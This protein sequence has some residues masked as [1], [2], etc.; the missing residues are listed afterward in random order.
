MH[1]LDL[2]VIGNCSIATLIDKRARMVWSC[3]PRL[4]G[5]PVFCNLLM[6]NDADQQGG[7]FEIELVGGVSCTQSYIENTAVLVT[8]LSDT[9]GNSLEITDYAPRFMQF[10]RIYRPPMVVRRVRPLKGRPRI[11][12]RAT[13][14][15][16]WGA[17]E[18]EVTR[19]NSHIRFVGSTMSLRLTT[20]APVAYL[21]DTT[22][23]VVDRPLA[24][25]FGAD[26]PLR[27]GI[28]VMGR[29][30]LEKTIAH[31]QDWVRSLSI[32]F[33]WQEAVIRSAITL[34]MCNFEETGAIVA[35][36][37]TSIPEAPSTGRNW[38]YRYC[39]VR[40]A[41]FVIQA[42]NRLGTTR[43]METYIGYIT[44][45]VD[46]E[47]SRGA[48]DIGPLFSVSRL[49]DR[50]E[51]IAEKLAGYRGMGP[52]RTGNGA[53]TQVQNDV[54]GSI[55]LASMHAFFDHRLVRDGNEILFER[56]EG[57]GHRATEVFDQPDAG[58]WELRTIASIHTFS[59]VMCWA[60][61]DR[62]AR[63]AKRIGRDDRSK[64]WRQR[65]ETI[66]AEIDRR[67]FSS[68]LGTFV[69]T[70]D[71]EDLDA[72]LLLLAE[73]GFVKAKDPRFIATVEAIGKSLRRGDL[74][75]RYASQDDFGHMSN[76]FLICGFWY[77]DA[78][79]AIGRREEAVAQFERL[80]GIRNTFGLLSEDADHITGELWGNFPQTYSMVG[81]INSAVRLSRPWE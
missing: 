80:L 41:Y 5:D 56:L 3:F 73:L 66:H 58:P 67:A 43:T 33:D 44:D 14:K 60:A 61:C 75:L 55:V 7:M 52:V 68:K 9:A 4:D 30:F 35:A 48:K 31:W 69:S 62:L 57:L 11:R 19:G 59:S 8:V 36:L 37:T 53:Y 12:V 10:D 46:D 24:F 1:S 72:T 49:S 25:F 34:K 51:R 76:G 17:D 18:P 27:A 29:E 23:F 26:E 40:D 13:P 65:A 15:F 39:W 22:P 32:P 42:L 45:I 77:V 78:L 54:Y 50:E 79:A 2:A 47:N 71:G 16:N 20:D 64:F 38:D 21:L 28:D 81:L 70:F 6:G 63:I 74:L